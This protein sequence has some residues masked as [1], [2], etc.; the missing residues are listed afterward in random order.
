MVRHFMQS[1]KAR[2]TWFLSR[3]FSI[4][5]AALAT[6]SASMRIP[7]ISLA[8]GLSLLLTGCVQRIAT[9][10]VG[11]IVDE[12]FTG[13][14]EESDLEL[15]RQAL[16]G[17]LKLLEVLLKNSPDNPTLLRLLSQGY[18]SYALGFV[19]DQ[20]PA[21]ARAFYLRARDY[22]ERVMRQDAKL[23]AGLDGSL[24][25]LKAAL[26]GAPK[27]RVPGVF[28]TAFGLGSYIQLNLTDPDALA[29]LPKAEA[30]MRFVDEKDSA[31]YYG[32][33][34]LFLGT[35]YGSRSRFLG[36]DYDRSRAWFEKAL[37]LNG[38]AFLMTQVYY[39]KSLAVQTLD[40]ELFDRLIAEVDSASIDVLPE[41][42]LANAIAKEKAV[43]LKGRKPEL[44]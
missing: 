7:S 29:E 43:R 39:A 18:S 21:R 33:A 19:E 10:T 30:M 9:N 6:P 44:F 42:R 32:G 28:W 35:L 23:A 38:R 3:V 2:N 25:D 16:P 17:N 34:S 4:L 5:S 26:A 24:E 1:R 8:L 22:G 11:D 37:R 13:F 41:N 12:G 15:A 36:G 14:T 31:F 40:E 20:D 27:D